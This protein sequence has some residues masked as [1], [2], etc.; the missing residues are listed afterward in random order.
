MIS[1]RPY[2]LAD[3]PALFEAAR[4]SVAEVHLWLSWC[5]AGY[6]LHDAET[7]IASK[8][9][10]FAAR[11]EFAF[12]VEDDAGRFLGGCG[13]NHIN[14]LHRLANLG[15]WVRSSAAGQGIAPHAVRLVAEWAFANTN[16]ERLE[17][18][19]AV[20]NTRSERVA[21]KAGA[22]REGLLRS[23][24]FFHDQPHDA[25]MYSLVRSSLT[26]QP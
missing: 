1:I 2:A 5:H 9:E 17:I 25:V 22:Q 10:A 4:E 14:E 3:A 7:W 23:R 11:R 20:G 24:L 15:Y 12:L 19:V 18:V 8:V 16:L 21:V 13:L 6:Q 26:E